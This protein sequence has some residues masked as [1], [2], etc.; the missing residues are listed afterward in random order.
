MMVCENCDDEPEYYDSDMDECYC[1]EHFKE[2]DSEYVKF[3]G[4]KKG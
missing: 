3:H 4:I 1:E 2:L